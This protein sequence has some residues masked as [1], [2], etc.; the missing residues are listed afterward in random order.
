MKYIIDYLDGQT[1]TVE[2]DNFESKNGFIEL[3]NTE[4]NS[5]S[6]RTYL[7]VATFSWAQ[8][9]SIKNITLLEAL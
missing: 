8:V 1:A 9:R 2:A 4:K 7:W 5:G 6:N 3:Y